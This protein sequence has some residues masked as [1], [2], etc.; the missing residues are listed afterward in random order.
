MTSRADVTRSRIFV[1]LSVELIRFCFFSVVQQDHRAGGGAQGRRQ[2]HE[3]SGD[4]RAGGSPRSAAA[5][6][7]DATACEATAANT[8]HVV[9]PGLPLSMFAA[10][11]PLV[12]LYN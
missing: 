1:S 8:C 12:P 7:A 4:L 5:A 9:S 6:A 2:Q 11:V 3:V 10:S